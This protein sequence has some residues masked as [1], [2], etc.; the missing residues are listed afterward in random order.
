MPDWFYHIFYRPVLFRLPAKIARDMSLAAIGFLIPF[1][2]TL[3][4][5]ICQMSVAPQ[6]RRPIFGIEFSSPIGLGAGL[7]VHNW[8][9]NALSVFGFGFVEIGP[10]TVEPFKPANSI[11]LRIKDNAIEYPNGPENDGCTA[12]K[13]RLEK[14]RDFDFKIGVRL[15]HTQETD[16]EQ[17]VLEVA[18]LLGELARFAD[19]LVLDTRWGPAASGAEQLDRTAYFMFVTEFIRGH[20]IQCP[21]FVSISPDLSNDQ[22]T[23]IIE[24]AA[25]CGMTGIVV[26]GGESHDAT[27]IMGEPTYARTISLISFLR[28][29]W[30]M[31]A[32]IG[33]GG[34]IEPHQAVDMLRAGVDLVQ[35]NSGF[36]FT[37]PGLT[38]R[39][40]EALAAYRLVPLLHEE[41]ESQKRII[42]P[43]WLWLFFLGA[44]LVIGGCVA[45]FVA[46][47]IIIL[48]NEE[49]SLHLTRAAIAHINSK[50]LRF[51]SID[52]TIH[53][54]TAMSLGIIYCQLAFFGVRK[55]SNWAYRTITVSAIVGFLSFVLFVGFKYFD[56]L[57]AAFAAGLLP[58]LLFGMPNRFV[59][60][61]R[62]WNLRNDAAWKLGL[63]G[64]FCFVVLGIGMVVAA[65][66]VARIGTAEVFLPEDL[67]YLHTTAKAIASANSHII[68]LIAHSRAVLGGIMLPT[69]IT[70]LLTSLWGFRE[71]ERWLW[72]TFAAAGLLPIVAAL[73]VNY[74]AGYMNPLHLAPFLVAF[75]FY[76]VGILCSLQFLCKAP[77]K[78]GLL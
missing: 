21:L 10:V 44:G 23:E 18:Q 2:R 15:A 61:P 9:L 42:G 59:N 19:Y 34:V 78:N 75:A 74:T 13:R 26:A 16:L 4:D 1:F 58:G 62:S 32:I 3:V 24:A 67:E 53:G 30:P 12:A 66:V 57:P 52:R 72:C 73:H 41:T 60:A 51:I 25:G 77:R 40:N 37:G 20:S 45:W 47:N 5:L 56:T 50:L 11:N 14:R 43:G 29:R 54:A 7:D 48:P 35:I 8:G 71:G 22:A 65:V 17:G 70:V 69:G 27:R 49:Q 38:K 31:M 64:Q 39:I 55:G 28:M 33:S 76:I 68:P 36:V 46:C 63:I 6:L